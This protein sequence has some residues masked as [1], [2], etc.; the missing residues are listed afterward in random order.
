MPEFSEAREAIAAAQLAATDGA[1]WQ[2]ALNTL[3][4]MFRAEGASIFT[5]IFDPDQTRVLASFGD[6]WKAS[7]RK[8]FSQW[9]S[10]DPCLHVMAKNPGLLSRAGD[11]LLGTEIVPDR[12]MLGT[13]YYND[14]SRHYFAGHKVT[15][16]LCD[17]NDPFSPVTHLSLGRKFGHGDGFT[18]EDKAKLRVIWPQLQRAVRSYWQLYLGRSEVKDA[19]QAIDVVPIP[20]WVVTEDGRIQYINKSARD[21]I[22]SS[23]DWLWIVADR[24]RRLGDLDETGVVAA[25]RSMNSG[26]ASLLNFVFV[27]GDKLRRGSLRA[28]PIAEAALFSRAWP[29]ARALLMMEIFSAG[30]PAHWLDGLTLHHRLTPTEARVLQLLAAGSEVEQIADQLKV[31][32]RTVGTHL[33]ALFEK[34][35]RRK[36]SELVRLVLGG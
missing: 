1:Q 35:G 28:V 20:T 32:R 11:V 18:K 2:A 16:K 30:T 31:S 12:L 23:Q 21:L 34:T 24:I 25:L 14:F 8:Y 15:I 10:E 7:T 6:D 26:A 5:P 22:P 3:A 4:R 29:R 33:R 19:E 13:A 9:V 27:E 36:Q 17:A